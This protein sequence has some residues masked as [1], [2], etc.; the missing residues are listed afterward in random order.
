MRQSVQN[1]P[2]NKITIRQLTEADQATWLPLWQG[3]LAFYKTELSELTIRTTWQRL[4]N[5]TEPM[6]AFG[7]FIGTELVGIV[8]CIYHRSCW[9]VGDYCYL[10]DL[11]TAEN[12]RNRGVATALI[13]AVY[14]RA[15][16][17]GASRVHW[18]THETNTNA[19][20]LYDKISARSGFIQYRKILSL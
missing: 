2:E 16:A 8:H 20:K 11:F 3:Y 19:Q 4:I 5:P 1:S 15:K 12:A 13:E 10:Q 18:L 14:A 7:A 9:T 17:D 6:F